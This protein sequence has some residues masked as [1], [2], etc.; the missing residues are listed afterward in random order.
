MMRIRLGESDR[1][2]RPLDPDPA[3]AA[4]P[5][6]PCRRVASVLQP[7]CGVI[8]LFS[9]CTMPGIQHLTSEAAIL[10]KDLFVWRKKTVCWGYH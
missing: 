9:S 8:G 7:V 1:E 6:E 3:H 5:S 10:W 4:S 2:V